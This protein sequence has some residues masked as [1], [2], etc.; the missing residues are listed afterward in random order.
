[1]RGMPLLF[2]PLA[3]LLLIANAAV[4]GPIHAL[5]FLSAFSAGG[6]LLSQTGN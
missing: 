6:W 3:A 4:I 2:L 1:M 5:V